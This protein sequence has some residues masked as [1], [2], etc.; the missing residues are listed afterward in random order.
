MATYLQFREYYNNDPE[1]REKIKNYKSEKIRCECG[2]DVSRSN[3]SAHKR[4]DAHKKYVEENVDVTTN[5]INKL[6]ERIAKLENIFKILVK[7]GT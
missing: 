6:K 3:M 4:S 2:K 7:D 5:E 1:F